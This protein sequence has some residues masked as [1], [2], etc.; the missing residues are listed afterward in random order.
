[1]R[2]QWRHAFEARAISRASA[3]RS[4]SNA[5]RRE[6]CRRFGIR[7]DRIIVIPH[8]IVASAFGAVQR[9]SG[10][11]STIDILFSGRLERRKGGEILVRDAARILSLD[12]RIRITLAGELDMGEAGNYRNAIERSISGDDRSRLQFLGPV[13][14]EDLLRLYGTLDMFLLPSLFENAPYALLE[15]MAAKLP[16]IAARTGGI[17]ELITHGETGLLF[18]IDN[19]ESLLDSIKRFITTPET[20]M[21]CAGKAYEFVTTVCTPEKIARQSM[22]FYAAVGGAG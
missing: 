22:E 20:A 3:Y 8:P 17:P 1:M 10:A 11:K 9:P 18:D 19:Q 15:A 14:R 4:P 12:P 5:M 6:A 21:A 13:M 2:Q 16:V 7:E